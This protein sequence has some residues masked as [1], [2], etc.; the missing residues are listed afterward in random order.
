MV[1]KDNNKKLL[2]I[3]NTSVKVKKKIQKKIHRLFTWMFVSFFSLY[4]A[5]NLGKNICANSF[6]YSMSTY[7]PEQNKEGLVFWEVCSSWL[8]DIWQQTSWGMQSLPHISW[9]TCL[10]PDWV[11]NFGEILRGPR[12]Q[13]GPLQHKPC[14]SRST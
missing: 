9:E 6:A 3:L 5:N 2:Q 13:Q 14:Q 10:I 7:N 8:L 11:S 1:K 4:C 12:T